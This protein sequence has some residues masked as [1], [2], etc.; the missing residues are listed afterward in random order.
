[1]GIKMYRQNIFD[2][3]LII[4][5]LFKQGVAKTNCFI[6]LMEHYETFIKN[7]I[8]IH[9]RLPDHCYCEN[10]TKQRHSMVVVF[11]FFN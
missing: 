5:L 2:V 11:V 3:I 9:E 4:T 6:R 1:M 7:K 10:I 8:P